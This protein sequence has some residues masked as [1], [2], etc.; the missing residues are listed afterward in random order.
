MKNHGLC[1]CVHTHMSYN[2]TATTHPNQTHTHTLTNA[3]TL[4]HTRALSGSP[5]FWLN[6]KSVCS[7]FTC[8]ADSSF[9]LWLFGGRKLFAHVRGSPP[10]RLSCPSSFV[11]LK[12]VHS[13]S[14]IVNH[15]I[16]LLACPSCR[17]LIWN[18][19]LCP[20]QS[21]VDARVESERSWAYF[22]R[23]TLRVAGLVINSSSH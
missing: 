14:Q 8:W 18:P 3:R 19:V 5:G 23:I 1:R 6:V 13:T 7:R 22:G 11:L 21:S 16:C 20:N 12:I 4:I 2:N 15:Q 10:R 9:G 17:L